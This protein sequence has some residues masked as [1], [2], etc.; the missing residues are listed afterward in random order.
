MVRRALLLMAILVS[1][2]HFASDK[3]NSFEEL[4]GVWRFMPVTYCVNPAG[5][6]VNADK[7][8]LLSAEDFSELVRQA[9]TKWEDEPNS[10][11]RFV[12]NGFCTNV[13]GRRDKVNVVGWRNLGR[14]PALGTAFSNES[15]GQYLRGGASYEIL[16]ADITVNSRV[17]FHDD[18]DFYLKTIL[19][20]TLLHEVG[21][22]IGLGHSDASCTVMKESVSLSAREVYPLELCQDDI[23]GVTRLYP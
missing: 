17:D 6:P 13:A 22:F 8:P 2:S 4:G 7:Q 20:F 10:N 16:E 9:F 15:S 18:L 23:D 5:L 11:I 14:R 1:A 21:H 3:A 19:P 12:H